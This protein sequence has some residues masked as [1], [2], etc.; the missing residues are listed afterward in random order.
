MLAKDAVGDV[1]NP[2]PI[3]ELKVVIAAFLA[4]RFLGR[5]VVSSLLASHGGSWPCKLLSRNGPLFIRGHGLSY[6][7]LGLV[8][9]RFLSLFAV[10]LDLEDGA[11]VG[12]L[13]SREFLLQTH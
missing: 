5:A 13:L 11:N 3:H 12:E 2:L 1:L 4:T 9:T 7:K 10:V 8:V 6:T